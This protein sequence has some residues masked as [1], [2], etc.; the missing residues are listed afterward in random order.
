[1][2]SR[3][4]IAESI[5]WQ[6]VLQPVVRYKNQSSITSK[7]QMNQPLLSNLGMIFFDKL[8][9]VVDEAQ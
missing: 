5:V 9:L 4:L 2:V 1:V 3:G 7:L 6:L 8:V